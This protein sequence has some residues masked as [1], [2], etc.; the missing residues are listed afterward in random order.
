MRGFRLNGWQRIGI[1]LSIVWTL[2]VS[3]WFFQHVPGANDPGIASVYLQCISAP[4]A[5]RGVCKARAEWFSEE[6]RS[7]FRAG[8]SW[9]ALAPIVVAWLLVYVVVWVVR[10]IRRDF[11]PTASES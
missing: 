6:A 7:E 1:V 2:C 10:W 8:W 9:A 3:M 11:Q 4:N 5:N